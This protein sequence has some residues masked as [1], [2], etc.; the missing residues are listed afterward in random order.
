VA[1]SRAENGVVEEVDLR[2]LHHRPR[3]GEALALAAADVGAAL[4]DRRVEA[5]GPSRGRSRRPARSPALPTSP[6]RWRPACRASGWSGRCRR[7][8]TRAAGSGRSP[9]RAARERGVVRR[10]RRPAALRR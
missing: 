3:D 2:A 9:T 4:G 6:R 8:G 5:L 1:R 10:R 7:T